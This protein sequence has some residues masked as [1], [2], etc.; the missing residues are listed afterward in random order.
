MNGALRRIDGSGPAPEPF[1]GPG[2]S[3]RE[4]SLADEPALAVAHREA[5]GRARGDLRAEQVAAVLEAQRA[6]LDV[7]RQD[8]SQVP[9][10]A[11]T[12]AGLDEL[13]LAVDHVHDVD[14]GAH[15]RLA[16]AV[17]DPAAHDRAVAE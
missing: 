13:A 14:A 5:Q 9:T 16:L 8:Q 7:H 1:K 3:C 11:R 12:Q 2:R 17:D 10:R 4:E 6:R 15:D